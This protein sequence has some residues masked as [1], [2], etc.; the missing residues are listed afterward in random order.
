[1]N[2]IHS[3]KGM[4]MCRIIYLNGQ[5]VPESEAR[6]S[7]FDRGT[8][9][10]DAVYD[11]VPVLSDRFI[12][13]DSHYSRLT[14]SLNSLS[15]PCPLSSEDLLKSIR[16]L[17]LIN[18]L[19]EGVVY[20]QVSRGIA[21]RDFLA[22]KELSPTVFMFT[23]QK[24]LLQHPKL[25]NGVRLKTVPDIRWARRDIKSCNL[26]GQILAKSTA[27]DK[28]ADDALMIESD[29]T[30]TECGSSSFFIYGD[31]CIV[32]RPLGTDILPGVTRNALMKLKNTRQISIEERSFTLDEV[33]AAEEA[34][35]SGASSLILPVVAVDNVPIGNGIPGPISTAMR[36][37]YIR[38]AVDS[39]IPTQ[40]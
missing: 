16:K 10:G 8:L 32:T 28:G 37:N 6:I 40:S 3:E 26:L 35:L 24:P 13:F 31:Q 15:I 17:V 39:G 19:P 23:Q 27:R 7:I 18:N 9:F 33:L 22:E 2:C 30:I 4:N 21:D 20:I 12:N 38:F 11:V 29:G 36:E 14:R 1:L 5:Y 25:T 34:F